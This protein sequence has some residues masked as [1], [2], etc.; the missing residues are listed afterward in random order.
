MLSG[1]AIGFGPAEYF[2]LMVFAFATLGSMVGSQP[3]KTLI[4]CVLGL[5]LATVGLDATS[6]AYRFTFNEPELGDGIEFVVLVIGLFSILEALLIL[7][8]QA[9]GHT[10]IRN[11]GR[12]FARWSDVVRSTG[13]TLR[14]SFIGFIVGVLP[15]T[16]SGE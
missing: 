2:V 5:M 6:G 1:I 16:G 9:K 10:V 3:A 4:G 12:M 14:G 8:N 11:M 7:E 13:A 15:G